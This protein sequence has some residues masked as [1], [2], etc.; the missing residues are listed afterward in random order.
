MLRGIA[1]IALW[2]VAPW[3]MLVLHLVLL[4]IA[5]GSSDES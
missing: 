3:F 5:G 1:Y 2:I 4:F